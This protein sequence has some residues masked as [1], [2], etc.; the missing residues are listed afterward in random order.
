MNRLLLTALF[1]CLFFGAVPAAAQEEAVP[2]PPGALVDVGGHFLHLYCTGE[3][4]PTVVIDAGLANW[5][6]Q[7]LHVQDALAETTRVCTYDRA[8]YGWSEPGPEPRTSQQIVDELYLLLTSADLQMPIVLVGH[9]FGALNAQLFANQHPDSVS[10]LVLID[11]P[12][13][14][15]ESSLP[16]EWGDFSRQLYKDFPQF[17]E[18]AE[19]GLIPPDS[20]DVPEG[21]PEAVHSLYQQQLATPGFFNTAFA[22]SSSFEDSLQ[23]VADSPVAFNDLP[24]VVIQR[25]LPLVMPEIPGAE[26]ELTPELLEAVEADNAYQQGALAL[27]SSQGTLITAE[28]SSHDVQFTEPE[29]IVDAVQQVIQVI[30]DTAQP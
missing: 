17:A 19:Q 25:G 30:N 2:P 5:S 8:G 4:S 1:A 27:L 16:P 29:V 15:V 26:I 24:I 12:N 28:N 21:L 20:I 9:S 6:I 3:G 18:F 7:W 13:P 14:R 22:E 10:G 23:Q 11:G